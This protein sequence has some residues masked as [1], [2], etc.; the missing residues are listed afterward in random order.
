MGPVFGALGAD[1]LIWSVKQ[2]K[3]DVQI[4]AS[5][6]RTVLGKISAATGWQIYLEPETEYVVSVKFKGLPA[7]VDKSCADPCYHVKDEK[8]FR[9]PEIFQYVSEHKQGKHVEKNMKDATVH[10]HIRD[11]LIR[12]EQFGSVVVKA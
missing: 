1:S 6:L 2:N 11:K 7:H 4:E 8:A 12:F 9:T 3:V 5:N 10:E